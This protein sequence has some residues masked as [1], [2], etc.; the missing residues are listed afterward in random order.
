MSIKIYDGTNSSW[1]TVNFPY[2]RGDHYDGT[3]GQRWLPVHTV[4][5]YDGGQW[6]ESH[7][8]A[9]AGQYVAGTEETFTSA[10]QYLVTQGTRY[11]R[12]TLQGGGGGGAGGTR[13][14]YQTTAQSGNG[15]TSYLAINQTGGTG[16][17]GGYVQV[18]IEVIPGETY[19]YSPG[20]NGGGGGASDVRATFGNGSLYNNTSRYSSQGHWF[21]TVTGNNGQNGIQSVVTGPSERSI[22]ITAGKGFGGTAYGGTLEYMDA[23]HNYG[24]NL[25][26]Y[27]LPTFSGQY[28]PGLSG[29][30]NAGGPS[31]SISGT[32]PD[33]SSISSSS[34]ASLTN[35]TSTGTK[36]GGSGGGGTPNPYPPPFSTSPPSAG[37]TGDSGY[38]KIL[39]YSKAPIS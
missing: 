21:Y 35:N 34:Y 18:T 7:R 33:G 38:V 22:S 24:G 32:N 9:L 13:L 31:N 15:A 29:P 39:P 30:S 10:G 1:K 23:S 14:I 12:L 28:G 25:I 19:A 4:H 20:N 6:K 5:V 11:L 2:V 37:S 3:S 27:Y 17:N 8:T 26:T 36:A 16:T